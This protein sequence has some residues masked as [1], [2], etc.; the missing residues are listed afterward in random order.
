[1]VKAYVNA[2]FASNVYFLSY[3]G[4]AVIIGGTPVL[5]KSKKQR[6][7]AL[8]STMAEMIG[9]SDQMQTVLTLCKFLKHQGFN[10]RPP[11]F[12]QDNTACIQINSAD[13]KT[14]M[15]K[16]MGL[17]QT[18]IQD[19]LK[20][21]QISIQYVP[22]EKMLADGLTKPLQGNAFKEFKVKILGH[23]LGNGLGY[24]SGKEVRFTE[25]CAERKFPQ[26]NPVTE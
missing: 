3:T 1:M 14:Q 23:E 8:N 15:S 18:D 13:G 16:H 26:T 5:V 21:G 10:L 12:Y 25:T 19:K 20:S 9:L 6:M 22:T 4:V 24:I 7:N 17:R 11:V 2:S